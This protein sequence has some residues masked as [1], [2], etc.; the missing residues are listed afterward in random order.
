MSDKLVFENDL[1]KFYE[2]D[3]TKSINAY[4]VH[5]TANNTP[6]LEH[7]QVFIA[8]QKSNGNKV[9]VLYYDKEPIYSCQKIEAM[10][11]YIDMLRLKLS[12]EARK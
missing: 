7:S 5:E 4:C 10:G 2:N 8:E 11:S 12:Y 1:C 9:Y 6:P 3:V